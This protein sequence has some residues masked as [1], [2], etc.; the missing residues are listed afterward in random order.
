MEFYSVEDLVKVVKRAAE[1]LLVPIDTEGAT[2]IGKRSRGTPRIANRL[3]RRVRDFAQIKGDGIISQEIAAK[4]LDLLEVDQLG[5]DKIDRRLLETIILKFNGGPVGLDTL[6]A[7]INEE[8]DTIED[9]YEPY[10]LQLGFIKRTP[11]GRVCT[12]LAYRHLGLNVKEDNQDLQEKL[13][14]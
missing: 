14:D 12:E 6:A 9:V 5:L 10:L 3:L 2:E 8:G 13:F 4:A 7:T 1:I 11:R